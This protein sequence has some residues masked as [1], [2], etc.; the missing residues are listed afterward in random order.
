MESVA[1]T[2]IT[3]TCEACDV[4]CHRFGVPPQWPS[5]V[6]LPAVPQDLH[7]TPSPHAWRDVSVG[8]QNAHRSQAPVERQLD[9]LHDAY[10]RRGWQHDHEG[11]GTRRGTLREG[12]GPVDCQRPGQ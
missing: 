4:R 5:A 3:M 2:E 7:R 6:S 8:G 10:Y 11:P 1:T 12:Y 9:S